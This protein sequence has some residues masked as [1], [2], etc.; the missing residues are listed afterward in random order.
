MDPALK[1]RLIGAAVLVALAVIFLPMLLGRPGPTPDRGVDVPMAIPVAPDR[2]LQTREIPLA[3]PEPA[4]PAEPDPSAVVTVDTEV[5][6]RIDAL[7]PAAGADS[8]DPVAP[9]APVERAPQPVSTPAPPRSPSQTAAAATASGTAPAAQPGGRHAVNLGS[10][11]QRA[12]A[13]ALAARLK[14][15]GLPVLTETISLD[16]KPATRV[17]VGPYATRGDAEAAR[18]AVRRLQADLP[19]A[20]VQLSDEQSPQAQPARPATAAAFA[21]QVGALRSETDATA[22]RD[23][24]RRAGFPAFT[25]RANTDDGPLWRVRAGPELTR[26][27]ADRLRADVKRKLALDGLVVSHP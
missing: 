11:S 9:V 7:Q 22:L 13:D 25:E 10:Y 18:I 21:V 2:N 27:R 16:G 26:E 24:L 20:V 8:P 5:A 14:Q 3:L 4:T 1:Q 17:R 15:A 19:A 12:N 23:R 6:P